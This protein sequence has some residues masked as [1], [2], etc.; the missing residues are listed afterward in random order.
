MGNEQWQKRSGLDI[1]AREAGVTCERG[2]DSAVRGDE[3]D[4][5]MIQR[6]LATAVR[7]RRVDTTTW[8]V[9]GARLQRS[10]QH[11][12]V[13]I[14]IVVLHEARPPVWTLSS[15][16]FHYMVMYVEMDTKQTGVVV[17]VRN[18]VMWKMKVS[19]WKAT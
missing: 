5:A 7:S 15:S 9:A 18:D 4:A 10:M 19:V 13:R 14:D 6:L 16:T 11:T 17:A 1:F 2:D 8:N 3:P 12:L